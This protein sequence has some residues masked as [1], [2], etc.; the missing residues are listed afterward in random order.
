MSRELPIPNEEEILAKTKEWILKSVIGLNLCPFAK[1]TFQSNTIRYVVSS[2]KTQ[3]E[4]L[5]DLETE[6]II[7]KEAVP[8]ITETTLLIHPYVLDDFFDQND[9][10]DDA[11]LLLSQLDLEGFIQIANFHPYF[12]FAET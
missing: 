9:F 11:D 3:K 8:A 5:K 2:S 12:Q 7:I 4:L 1:P 10:L 6:L